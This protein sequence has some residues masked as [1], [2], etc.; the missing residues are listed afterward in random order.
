VIQLEERHCPLCPPDTG[1]RVKYRATFRPEDLNAEVFSARRMPDRSHFQFLECAGCGLIYSS[2]ACGASEL[3]KL[4]LDSEVS[5]EQQESQIFDSYAPVL[6]RALQR[7]PGRKAFV[8][9]GG[10][11]GFMLDYGRRHGFATQIE[12]EPSADAERRFQAQPGASFIRS[13]FGNGVVPPKSASLVCFFQMLDHVPQPLQFLQAVLEALE[14]GGVAI[15]VTHNTAALSASVLGERSP[16]FDIEHTYLYNTSNL[17]KLFRRA[18]FDKVE[19]FPISNSY[20]FRHW[21]HLAPIPRKTKELTGRLLEKTGAL[22]VR[23]P[24][25][26]GNF[27]VVAERPAT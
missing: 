26:A 25:R 2:P 15:C 9:V 3:A 7:Q 6:D 23:I 11:R 22:D 12:I 8:E 19:A 17:P 24:V 1:T 13:M 16:I 14:P 10:G 20:A 5:Y 21:L 4:Y 27:A 18:G